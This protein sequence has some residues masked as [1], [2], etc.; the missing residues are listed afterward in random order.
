M[1]GR[2][3]EP[4]GGGAKHGQSVF[5]EGVS[6]TGE[7]DAAGDLR[8]DGKLKGKLKTS[9]RITIGPS[10]HMEA[11]LEAAEVVIMGH[12]KGTIVAHRRL[13]LRKGAQ[14]TADVSTSSLIIEEGVFFQGKS[15]MPGERT[16]QAVPI[17]GKQRGEH[18]SR[19]PEQSGEPRE[20]VRS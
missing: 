9:D 1:F 8:F 4:A 5:Q 17:N 15:T 10:G 12:F 14:V 19:T 2:N 11:E 18:G 7:V 13:E 6:I 16:I 20:A 3:A